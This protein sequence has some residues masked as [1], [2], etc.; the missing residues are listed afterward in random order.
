MAN[1]FN[2]LSFVYK[3]LKENLNIFIMS[4]EVMDIFRKRVTTGYFK[5]NF[6]VID[7]VD[8]PAFGDIE[9]L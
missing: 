1:F 3:K 7:R 6:K 4:E 9:I 5:K 8:H 2:S